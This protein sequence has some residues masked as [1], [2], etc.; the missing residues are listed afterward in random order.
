M[1][2]NTNTPSFKIITRAILTPGRSVR[3]A[4]GK[5]RLDIPNFSPSR[6]LRSAV[7]PSPSDAHFPIGQSSCSA[8]TVPIGTQITISAKVIHDR[9]SNLARS[10][11][12]AC[13]ESR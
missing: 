7:N 12:W 5:D 2:S 11:Q 8:N 4:G 13:P 1:T 6:H 9:K 10:D 3:D